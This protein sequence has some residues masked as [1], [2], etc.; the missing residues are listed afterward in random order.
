[1]VRLGARTNSGCF[2]LLPARWTCS[3]R[4]RGRWWRRSGA[5]PPPG[6]PSPPTSWTA[7]PAA[8][9]RRRRRRGPSCRRWTRCSP[10][11]NSPGAAAVRSQWPWPPRRMSGPRSGGRTRRSDG[12]TTAPCAGCWV[13]WLL[14]PLSL[15]LFL[16]LW[17]NSVAKRGRGD[18]DG[19]QSRASM[20]A[21]G[22]AGGGSARLRSR[23]GPGRSAKRGPVQ[24]L[25]PPG[26]AA[27]CARPPAASL[28]DSRAQTLDDCFQRTE[29]RC[30][31]T[32]RRMYLL[33]HV[34]VHMYFYLLLR[35]VSVSLLMWSKKKKTQNK[36]KN[37]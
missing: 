36:K 14:S 10:I 26:A 29:R 24:G 22:A 32:E 20:S 17:L 21:T 16:V 3:G 35:Q 33:T 15:S 23:A 11:G 27:R 31:T 5:P 7:P 4:G 37:L 34:C 1:M 25:R 12:R 30:D 6:P 8:W 2:R 13:C 19:A 18:R 9:L 28:P